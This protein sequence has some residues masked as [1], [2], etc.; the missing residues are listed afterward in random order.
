M[1]QVFYFISIALIGLGIYLKYFYDVPDVQETVNFFVSW[2]LII[3]GASSLLI[4]LSWGN[5]SLPKNK[6]EQ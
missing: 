1:K 6:I 4:N 2:F 3:I 5:K